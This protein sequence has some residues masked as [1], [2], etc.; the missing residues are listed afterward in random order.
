MAYE[1]YNKRL[2]HT[3]NETL[4]MLFMPGP[5][6]AYGT[7]F[8]FVIEDEPRAIKVK[9]ETRIPAGRYKLGIRKEL[10]TLT[11]KNRASKWYKGWFTYHIEVLRVPGFTG[12]YFHI[13]NKEKD[14]A[15]CQ[16]GSKHA[17]IVEGGFVCSNSTEMIREFYEIVYP[18]LEKGEDV[19]YTI[20]NE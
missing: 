6:K 2:I 8:G 13:G 7:P 19:Y 15:G 9:G 14:T 12:I 4:G 20:I 16:I 11:K 1:I 3:T 5:G 17:N 10:T 18:K